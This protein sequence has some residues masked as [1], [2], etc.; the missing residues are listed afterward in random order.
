MRIHEKK[1]SPDILIPIALDL[2][3][4]KKEQII[5]DI[6]TQHERY[7][8][9][10]FALAAPS[11]GWRSVGYP[12]QLF[13]EEKARLFAEIKTELE[14]DGIECGWWITATLKSGRSDAFS[15]M[16]DDNGNRSFFAN[17][18]LDPCFVKTF[19]ENVAL[20]ARIAHPAFIIT[21]DDY[22]VHAGSSAY[23]CFCKHH[24]SA[25]AERMGRAYAREELVSIFASETEEAFTLLREWRALMKD[26]MVWI[27]QKIREAVDQKTPEIPI[28]YMQPGDAD[29]DGDCTA[30]VA[31]ALA[32]P[33]HAP[34]SRFFGASYCGA[35][36]KEIP[37]VLYHAIY[38]KQH[39]EDVVAY[40]ES[41][42]FP[43]TRFFTSAAFMR[44]M[45]SIVYSVGFD[46]STF[47]TQQL[48]DDPNEETAYGKMFR[49]ERRRFSA[50]HQIVKQCRMRGV[51]ICY[52]P[53][54]NTAD[55]YSNA[56]RPLWAR[57]IGL[58]GIP[59][60]TTPQRVAFWDSRQ[61][62]HC[63]H[64]AVMQYLSKG[65]I[66]DGAAAAVLTARGYGKYLGVNVSEEA[67]YGV[68]LQYDLAAREV[69]CDGVLPTLIGRNMPS[70]HMFAKGNNGQLLKMTVTDP[71]CEV[72]SELVSFERNVISPVM[73][74]FENEL[75]GRIVVMG[76]T[77]YDEKRKKDNLS[78]SLYNYRRQ[79]LLQELVDW[80]GGDYVAVM[81]DANIMTVMNE[82]SKPKASDFR[83]M[84]TLV[85]L[86]TDPL[87]RVTVKLPKH[88]RNPESI[89][90]L[91]RNGAWIG[92][93]FTESNGSVT[94]ERQIAFGEPVCLLL[95]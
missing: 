17:C 73:T 55:R 58:F 57:P 88:L 81:G 95:R 91:N 33:R 85:N 90:Y 67:A 12:P 86:G 21:E 78:Q 11:G 83:A 89:S 29:A 38:S 75:G 94:V 77:L 79:R 1:A 45:M 37:R 62:R 72:L 60:V 13:F 63:D 30:A 14:S 8:F 35:D 32:G 87:D 20:F 70:P 65:L 34:F 43:H 9:S 31:R 10:R 74:R 36:G 71:A 49:E 47:Q 53:F 84:L 44:A 66:L 51:E 48:L 2:D 56:P 39:A 26:S 19:S 25:F 28:G 24:L 41:D 42:T 22:S 7:G 40:H 16:V 50:L 15:G 4:R 27:S 52:D 80:C 92:Q 59:Y 61:A 68:P 93:F 82:P 6:R 5:A 23:G 18:P 3:W 76:V 46:G 54:W 69:L 64:Q